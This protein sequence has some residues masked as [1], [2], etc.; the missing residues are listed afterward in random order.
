MRVRHSKRTESVD[1]RGGGG[2]GGVKAEPR[3]PPSGREG[4]QQV[5]TALGGSEGQR[6]TLVR[7]R[8]LQERRAMRTSSKEGRALHRYLLIHA[9]G[10][11]PLQFA[12]PV[13]SFI[14]WDVC[15]RHNHK[16]LQLS[17]PGGRGVQTHRPSH[18]DV[19]ACLIS[20]EFRCRTR[21]VERLGSPMRTWT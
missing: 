7:E 2:G 18:S 6:A 3:A 9:H 4:D 12:G 16:E 5:L 21:C 15:K 14:V 17:V 11:D 13:L 19:H 20:H 8:V 1:R 10:V